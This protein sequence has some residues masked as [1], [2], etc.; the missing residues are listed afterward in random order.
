[1]LSEIS[2]TKINTVYHYMWNPKNNTNESI[3]K[4]ETDSQ[5][6]KTN[7]YKPKGRRMWRDKLGVWD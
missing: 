1:M 7:M 2:Q 3:Y 6:W 4:I 5:T